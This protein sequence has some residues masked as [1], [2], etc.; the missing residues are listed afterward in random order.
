VD[1]HRRFEWR[2]PYPGCKYLFLGYGPASIE[3]MRDL[4]LGNHKRDQFLIEK[5]IKPSMPL[6]STE[7]PTIEEPLPTKTPE[8]YE[9]L[10]ITVADKAFLKT[11][12]IS[13]K[14]WEK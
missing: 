3:A 2:C 4:H 6:A 7:V 12:G 11:R 1:Q 9:K 5:G 13:I 10:E 8:E 14:E